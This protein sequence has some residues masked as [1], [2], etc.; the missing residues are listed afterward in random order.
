MTEK[1]KILVVL[2]TCGNASV[3]EGIA[4]A[5]VG[6]HLA[7]CV[8]RIAGV[9]STYIWDGQVVSEDEVL[10]VIKT[11]AD[12]FP[13]L[14]ARLRELHPYEVP[15]ILALPVCAGAENYLDWVRDSVAASAPEPAP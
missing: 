1:E 15:E 6:D 5:L 3:G 7:A 10:L 2:T 14:Q 4:R 13:A 12:R 11:T 9:A 8:N